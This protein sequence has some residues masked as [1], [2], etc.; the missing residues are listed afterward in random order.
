M[1]CFLPDTKKGRR[2]RKGKALVWE[3]MGLIW[4]SLFFFFFFWN[5]SLLS[6]PF[7]IRHVAQY[8]NRVYTGNSTAAAMGMRRNVVGGFYER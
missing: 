1:G 3:S 5:Y 7:A 6:E 2:I 8:P 4:R